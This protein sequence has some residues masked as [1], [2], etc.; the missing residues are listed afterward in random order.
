MK[1]QEHQA[2]PDRHAAH[3]AD[4]GALAAIESDE[5]DQE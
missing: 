4:P 5:P 3:V 1:R 2:E